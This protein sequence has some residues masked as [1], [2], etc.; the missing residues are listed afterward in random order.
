MLLANPFFAC[1]AKP[2]P[3]CK[4]RN[5]FLSRWTQFVAF[6]F[7]LSRKGHF[8][9]LFC[10]SSFFTSINFHLFVNQVILKRSSLNFGCNKIYS[11][12]RIVKTNSTPSC[13]CVYNLTLIGQTSIYWSMIDSSQI[14]G[15][16]S[17]VKWK[18]SY[19]NAWGIFC[20]V[21]FNFKGFFHR[22]V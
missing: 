17:F 11:M 10:P 2:A 22:R 6:N 13:H 16:G 12:T 14:F 19:L 21:A 1:E 9:G 7:F 15:K 20:F 4:G 5:M 8:L 18:V 3:T